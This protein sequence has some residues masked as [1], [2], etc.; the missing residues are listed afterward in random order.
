MSFSKF[1]F[2]LSLCFFSFFAKAQPANC[3]KRTFLRTYTHEKEATGASC[4]LAAADGNI[5][6]GGTVGERV[7]IA[8]IRPD[9]EPLWQQVLDVETGTGN[10][11][12]LI[13][14]GNAVILIGQKTGKNADGFVVKY[15]TYTSKVNWTRTISNVVLERV[16]DNGKNYQVV[17]KGSSGI[18]KGIQGGKNGFIFTID[19][20]SGKLLTQWQSSDASL[21]ISDAAVFGKNAC[22]IW[23]NDSGDDFWA[24]LSENG[25]LSETYFAVDSKSITVAAA[26][27]KE[28]LISVGMQS[29]TDESLC[30]QRFNTKKHTLDWVNNY[31]IKDYNTFLPR[32]VLAS[33]DGFVV[34]GLL[35]QYENARPFLMQIDKTGNVLWA[36]SYGEEGMGLRNQPQNQ[37]LVVLNNYVYFVNTVNDSTYQAA[38]SSLPEPSGKILLL[39]V[40]LS[41]GSTNSHCTLVQPLDVQVTNLPKGIEKGILKT[42]KTVLPNE[43]NAPV[44]VP[45]KLQSEYICPDCKEDAQ[46]DAP[47][48]LISVSPPM[49]EQNFREGQSFAIHGL[50]FDA[51]SSNFT[52]KAEKALEDV[53]QYLMKH[54]NATVEIAG[55]TNGLCDSDYC[56]DLSNRRAAAVMAYIADRAEREGKI[57]PKMSAKGYGKR[58]HI[59]TNMTLSGRNTNQRVEIKILKAEKYTAKTAKTAAKN[60]PSPTLPK[61]KTAKQKGKAT[62]T[63]TA[64]SHTL[65]A[66][67]EFAPSTETPTWTL[68]GNWV[69]LKIIRIFDAKGKIVYSENDLAAAEK[70]AHWKAEAAPKGTY[71]YYIEALYKDGATVAFK[72]EVAVEK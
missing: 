21:H 38:P 68:G 48:N 35:G 25:A 45:T 72:G 44:A 4:L 23:T 52:L 6:I 2:C 5:L 60:A 22:T 20:A 63:E 70:T 27:D 30:V 51:D 46:E 16:W 11:V 3:D 15:D 9:G 62:K 57:A 28:T 31:K 7:Y 58:Q 36:K 53:Y 19:K 55:H 8:K 41:D 12:G 61:S 40:Q 50:V 47:T 34:A 14:D 29:K 49:Q 71:F 17:G 18:E 56:D 39:K 64:I 37:S 59:A 10:V 24:N 13:S 1:S 54:P 66:P 42:E 26:A 32:A 65:V 67:A 33:P 43:G 69:S